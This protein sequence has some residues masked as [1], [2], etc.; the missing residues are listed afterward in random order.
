[1]RRSRQIFY[2]PANNR[3]LS[4]QNGFLEGMNGPCGEGRQAGLQRGSRKKGSAAGA[5]PAWL[6][7]VLSADS[8]APGR[9][10]KAGN[11]PLS[12]FAGAGL[13]SVL[14]LLSPLWHLEETG[15]DRCLSW[16]A[17]LQGMVRG[18]MSAFQMR[19][20]AFLKSVV[21]VEACM[22]ACTCTFQLPMA[23]RCFPPSPR[24]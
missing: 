6:G 7:S 11:L 3:L 15:M 1:M 16:V 22:G 8:A 5:M 17:S 21:R 18:C 14:V 12:L 2:Y 20:R 13:A 10:D 4:R 19:L 24:Q 23:G 9:G